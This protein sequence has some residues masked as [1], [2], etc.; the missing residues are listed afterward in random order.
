MAPPASMTLEK[1][2]KAVVVKDLQSL[3]EDEPEDYE[4]AYLSTQAGFVDIDAFRMHDV[5]H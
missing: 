3:F 1:K 4:I 2:R 5:L